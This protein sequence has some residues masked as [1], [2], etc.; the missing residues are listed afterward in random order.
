MRLKQAV[1]GA[2]FILAFHFSNS[3]NSLSLNGRIFESNNKPVS[4]AI[5]NL[6]NAKNLE[7]VKTVFSEENG[8]FEFLNLGADS[9]KLS[10]NHLGF[11]NYLSNAISLNELNSPLSID[12]IILNE[13][14]EKLQEVVVTSKL[15]FV[16]RKIDRTIVNPDALIS[17]AG[18]S[19]LEVIAK[20]PGVMVDQNDIIKLKG[21]QGVIILVDNKPTYLAGNE[22]AS[23]LKSIPASSIKQ[24]EIMTNPPAHFEAAGNAGI[25]NIITKKSK[26]K[27]INGTTNLNFSQ[28]RY[29]RTANNLSLNYTNNR[30]SVFSGV[31]ASEQNFYQDLYIYRTLKNNDQEVTSVFNQHTYSKVNSQMYSARLGLDYY[32]NK[33]TTIG[34]TS[35]GVFSPTK[36]KKYN[37]ADL[38]DSNR[39]L[40]SNVIADNS[41]SDVFKNA[42]FNLNFR[43]QFDSLG[44]QLTV[45]ADYVAYSTNLKQVFLND[46]ILPNGTN[47]YKDMQNGNTP[48]DITIYAF[49]SDFSTPL[50]NDFKF[51][52]GLKTSYTKTDNNAVYTKTFN[53]TTRNN[54]DLSNHFIYNEMINAGYLNLNKSFKRIDLQ[55]GLRFEST[56]LNGNQLGNLKKAPSQF[57]RV[58]NNIF[59]T[60]FLS[61]KLDTNDHHVLALNYGKRVNRPFYKD[62][63]P[64]VSPLDKYTYYVGNPYLKPTFA[65][66]AS[67]AY[68]F[69]SLFTTTFS[70]AN[71]VDQIQETIEINEGLYYS[72]PGNIGSSV[73]Y[74]LSLDASIPIKKWLTTNIYTELVYAE[75]QSR[76]YT[77]TLNAKGTYWYFN[78]NNSIQFGKGWSGELS[79]E[80][81]SDF[82]DSQFGF[83]DFGSI[84]AGV[85]KK[86]LKDKGTLKFNISDVFFTNKIRGQIKYLKNAEAGWRSRNDPQVASFTFSYRFG[87]NTNNKQKHTSNGSESEQNRVKK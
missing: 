31:S 48:S 85:Q 66:N 1:F 78:A 70:Y 17:T 42:S 57:N 30:I 76:L 50:K 80:Y 56:I 18:T 84:S 86:I 83:G 16:E 33:K 87:K 34:F 67:V 59:P 75:F 46:V 41:E 63:N 54:Y 43:H 38:L 71:T 2:L 81:I 36:E 49:K 12:S 20:S 77:E 9:F 28:G 14:T 65:H 32:L 82:I 8:G 11:K 10:I 45:D 39:V 4:G 23:Y 44:K 22:L 79:G 5:V 61:F 24:I 62:L 69:K 7:L 47:I 58:Y 35:K 37:Y 19:A 64:F 21:K 74:N 27:G 60:L 55:S 72:R 3:Q 13:I 68:S 6:V 25:I 73:V 29:A 26:L 40:S 53:D 51:D 15:N 52:A